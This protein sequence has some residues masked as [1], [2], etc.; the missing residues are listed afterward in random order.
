M[1]SHESQRPTNAHLAASCVSFT[2]GGVAAEQV[3]DSLGYNVGLKRGSRACSSVDRA[4][5]SGAEGRRFESCRARQNRCTIPP[6]NPRFPTA[7]FRLS[8]LPVAEQERSLR[9]RPGPDVHNVSP[10]AAAPGVERSLR[11]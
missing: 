3:I 4:S 7:H 5:A 11:R 2:S 8:Q 10:E 1:C 6:P 9:E